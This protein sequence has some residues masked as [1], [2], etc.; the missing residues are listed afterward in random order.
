M[1][2]I[3]G[4]FT[5]PSVNQMQTFFTESLFADIT[6][7]FDIECDGIQWLFKFSTLRDASPSSSL[8]ITLE[9]IILHYRRESLMKVSQFRDFV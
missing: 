9:I 7:I 6:I 5:R 8:L 2:K 1:N 4:S 3:Y